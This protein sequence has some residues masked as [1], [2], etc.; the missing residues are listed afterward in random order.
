MVDGTALEYVR[1]PSAH[2]RK[3]AP[4]LVFLHEGLGSVA[5]WR[6]F[7]QRVA[8]RCGCPAL[9]YSR[10]GYGR[11]GPARLPRAVDYMHHEGLVVLPAL[12]AALDI[13]RPILCGHSDGASIALICA[14]GTPTELTGLILMAPHVRVEELTVTSIAGAAEAYR[15]TDLPSR[16][17]RHHAD[18]DTAF[19]GWNEIWLAPAFRGW[20][21]EAFLPAIHCPVLTIQGEDDEY[22]T[23]AQIDA[24]AAAVGDVEQCRLADCRHS[25]HKDQTEAA[26][27][28]MGSFVDRLLDA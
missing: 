4:T 16:L 27:D 5:M 10:A 22:G 20:N 17:A 3:G 7:P 1:L 24:I 25:P 19:W 18:P 14:G 23:M 8:D 9:V 6:D 26:L 2:P 12:L 13:H 15:E 28:A 11:S 21:I